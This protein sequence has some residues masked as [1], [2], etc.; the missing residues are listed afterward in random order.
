MLVLRNDGRSFDQIR[1]VTISYDAFGYADSS[2]LFEIGQT[3]VFASISLQKGVPHFMK[4]TNSGW[5]TAEFAMSTF[6]TRERTARESTQ[7]RLNS[8]SVEISRLIGRSL[9]SVVDVSQ[10][11]ERT[12]FVDCDVLQADG[13]TRVASITAASLALFAA[14]SRWLKSGLITSKI[15]KEPI[16][17][18]SVGVLNGQVFL[19]LSQDEDNEADADF[20]FIMTKSGKIVEIQGTSE[21]VPLSWENFAQVKKYA[22]EG[23]AQ[24]FNISEQAAPSQ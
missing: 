6:S 20:N 11:G 1:P 24:L 5:L 21:K 16:A 10:L 15:I 19:D 3:K 8:R 2:V 12:I 7:N 18:L 23:V 17:A 22:L 13:G 14:E 4:G 9:R